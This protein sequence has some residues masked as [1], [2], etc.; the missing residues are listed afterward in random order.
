MHN[1]NFGLV[2]LDIIS[3]DII[4]KPKYEYFSS[5]S[6]CLLQFLCFCNVII[7]ELKWIIR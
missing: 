5:M 7:L 6:N 4:L 1:I 2:I 3:N